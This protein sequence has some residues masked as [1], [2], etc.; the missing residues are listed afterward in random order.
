MIPALLVRDGRLSPVSADPDPAAAPGHPAAGDPGSAGPWTPHP[1]A[2][3]P[4]PARARPAP[5][6]GDPHRAG[7]RGRTDDL[8]LRRRRRHGDD[9]VAWSSTRPVSAHPYP[10]IRPTHPPAGHPAGAGVGRVLPTPGDPHPSPGPLPVAVHPD[11][12]RP[13]HD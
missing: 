2:R 13:G 3:H 7:K 6:P 1:I 5:V 9:G 11:V 8:N 12:G 4:D 10:T